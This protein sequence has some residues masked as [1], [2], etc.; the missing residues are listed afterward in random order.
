MGSS[1]REQRLPSGA[2]RLRQRDNERMITVVMGR[3]L[4]FRDVLSCINPG[5]GASN[6]CFPQ[7][8]IHYD[9][10]RGQ[11]IRAD[12]ES[13]GEGPSQDPCEAVQ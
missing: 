6:L 1:P 2:N 3:D 9:P 11:N 12:D 7:H 10:E 13:I 5:A 8:R 4:V